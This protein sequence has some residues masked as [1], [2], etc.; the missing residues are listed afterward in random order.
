MNQKYINIRNHCKDDCVSRDDGLKL[1][2]WIEEQWDKEVQLVFDFDNVLIAS[3]SFIDEAFA[4]L[5]FE[6]GRDELVEKLKFEN[7]CPF[8]R[9][10]LNDLIKARLREKVSK[11]KKKSGKTADRAFI[12]KT[13]V[14]KKNDTSNISETGKRKSGKGKSKSTSKVK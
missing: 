11:S 12:R 1:R 6:H 4:K 7:L 13:I 2:E 9:A 5:A 8:D 14:G 10:L 3:V